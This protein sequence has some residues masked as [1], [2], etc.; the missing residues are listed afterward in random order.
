[1]VMFGQLFAPRIPSHHKNP[2]ILRCDK[3]WG[4]PRIS[5][6]CFLL[7]QTFLV[8]NLLGGFPM[9]PEADSGSDSAEIPGMLTKY[10]GMGTLPETDSE[11]TPENGWLEDEFPVGMAI[12]EATC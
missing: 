12:S 6:S 3:A 4:I 11:F 5:M 7:Q 1:M 10:N 2:K 9:V 8:A